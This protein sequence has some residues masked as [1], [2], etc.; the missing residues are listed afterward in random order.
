MRD[1]LFAAS[2]RGAL[3]LA[4][5]SANAQSVPGRELL[6]FPVGALV[7]APA[8]ATHASGALY[9]PATLLLAPAGGPPSRTRVALGALT[10]PAERGLEGEVASISHLPRPRWGGALTLARVAVNGIDRTE[11]TPETVLG[12]VLYDAFTIS[13]AGAWRAHRHLVVGSAVR[14]RLGRADTTRASMVGVDAGVVADGLLGRRDLRVA[15]S[16]YLW[17]PSAERSDRPAI[18]G[19]VDARAWGDGAT[20]EARVGYSVGA[21]RGGGTETFAYASGRYRYVEA[22]AG[23]ARISAYGERV[24]H[25][26]FGVGLHYARL[27][28]GIA[29]ETGSWLGSLT[30]FTFSIGFQ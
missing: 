28:A 17:S 13:A 11:T 3:V 29:Q 7:E 6:D 23:V 16:S 25:S 20:R 1:M 8:L 12:D 22:R 10:S 26:R 15:L 21:S 14:Y 2:W 5:T 27:S 4:A 19:A 24:T 30:Q 9:N 18:F